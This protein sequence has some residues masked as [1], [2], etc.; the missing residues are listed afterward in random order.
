MEALASHPLVLTKRRAI[1]SILCGVFW[2][3]NLSQA[4]SSPRPAPGSAYL[5]NNTYMCIN[6]W[7]ISGTNM[8]TYSGIGFDESVCR[9]LCSGLPACTTYVWFVYG[10]C[11][12][13]RDAFRDADGVTG[14]ST[15]A[16]RSCIKKDLAVLPPPPPP[17]PPPFKV[18]ENNNQQPGEDVYLIRAL[19]PMSAECPT[20]NYLTPSQDCDMYGAWTLA[21]FAGSHQAWIVRKSPLADGTYIITNYYRSLVADPPC[22]RTIWSYRS[23]CQSTYVDMWYSFDGPQ[24]EV[25]FEP[26]AG[27]QGA[28]RIRAAGRPGCKER[29][30]AAVLACPDFG[31][32]YWAPLNLL[33]PAFIFE[34]VPMSSAYPVA[35][36][37]THPNYPD[38]PSSPPPS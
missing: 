5:F 16:L 11:V 38:A 18:M 34:L 33:D 14:A 7:E 1:F 27:R 30:L 37:P 35:D 17:P 28:L 6:N 36:M 22:D 3:S 4:Q 25:Y 2:L 23:D 15:T 12:I 21:E 19:G 24:Q 29:Y 8:A 31:S 32:V 9:F 13:R 26:V 10:Q 20:A